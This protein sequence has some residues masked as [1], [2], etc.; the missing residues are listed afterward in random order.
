MGSKY[1]IWKSGTHEAESRGAYHPENLKNPP[2]IL[3]SK[4]LTSQSQNMSS[5]A[6]ITVFFGVLLNVV[7]LVGFFG[8]GAA[9]PTALIP[10]AL[11]VLLIICGLL[12]RIEKIR[13][14]IMHVAVLIGLLGFGATVSSYGLLFAV[15]KQTAGDKTNSAIAK[16]ATALLCGLFVARCIQ[17]FVEARV[18]K[19]QGKKAY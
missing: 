9:H 2:S 1:L 11:G 14:H 5:M 13:M 12:A 18:L 17:S 4:P 8:T 16:M 15:L 6:S 7:G 19:K 3:D 10:C